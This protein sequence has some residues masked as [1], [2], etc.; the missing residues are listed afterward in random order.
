MKIY[1]SPTLTPMYNP[2]GWP[3]ELCPADAEE[4]RKERIKYAYELEKAKTEAVPLFEFIYPGNLKP[5]TFIDIEIGEV[6]VVKQYKRKVWIDF[7]PEE[8]LRPY[9]IYEETRTIARIK[10]KYENENYL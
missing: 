9:N 8:L 7:L 6:E 3:K 1:I 2:N 10:P 5:D 4:A